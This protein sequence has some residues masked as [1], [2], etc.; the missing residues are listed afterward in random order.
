MV[1]SSLSGNKGNRSCGY[2]CLV[3]ISHR[4]SDMSRFRGWCEGSL[5][6]GPKPSWSNS[7]IVRP[8]QVFFF[9]LA[10]ALVYSVLQPSHLNADFSLSSASAAEN[11]SLY[12]SDMTPPFLESDLLATI[13]SLVGDSYINHSE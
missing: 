7:V 3:R 12:L 9:S 6:Q 2:P 13:L 4:F 8:Q 1:R 11:L 10:A 5:A